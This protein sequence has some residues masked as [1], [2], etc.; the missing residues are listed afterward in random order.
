M[1]SPIG[2]GVTEDVS[3]QVVQDAFSAVDGWFDEGAPFLRSAGDGGAF[4]ESF[5]R[6]GD[7]LT[8]EALRECS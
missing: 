6:H 5:P 1:N 2:D 8:G 4:R 7:E 3:G